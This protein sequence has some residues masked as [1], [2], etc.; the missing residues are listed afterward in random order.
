MAAVLTFHTPA[1]AVSAL[2]GQAGYHPLVVATGQVAFD[3]SYPTGG[4]SVNL[5]SVLKHV[6][7]I[8]FMG[9]KS[10]YLFEADLTGGAAAV[11]VLVRTPV[12]VQAVHSHAATTKVMRAFFAGGDVKGG[13]DTDSPNADL[14]SEPTNGHAVAAFATVAAGTWACGAITHPDRPRSVGITVYNDSGGPLNL[15]EGASAFLVTGTLYGAVQ[16]ETITITSTAGNKAVA[17]TKY[18]VLYGDKAFSTVTSITL[19]N[20]PADG[21][22]IGAGLGTHFS[23][24]LTLA[25]P[26]EAD[27]LDFTVTAARKAV[28]G[29]V[30]TVNNTVNVEAIADA[31]DF[32]V[33]YLATSYVSAVATG[34]AIVAAVAAE[35]ADTTNLST[36]VV[37]FV[38]WGLPPV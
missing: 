24:P 35:V 31:A 20:V 36:L 13:A 27:V 5:S 33:T 18:R 3:D 25:T 7:G 21:L 15:F 28:T 23:L 10:G 1:P 4:E 34:G 9:A 32:E 2:R 11:K 29:C 22:K 30:D 26:V 14:A 16:T 8:T 17:T 12:N 37:G 19:N 6:L 38:A